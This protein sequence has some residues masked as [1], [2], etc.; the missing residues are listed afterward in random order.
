MKTIYNNVFYLFVVIVLL[1]FVGVT[2]L[3]ILLHELI[4]VK[5]VI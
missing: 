3:Y 4:R 5:I 1:L 2:S